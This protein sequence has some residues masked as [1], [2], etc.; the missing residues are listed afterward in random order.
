MN[1][2]LPRP[3]T[4]L[5]GVLTSTAFV[6]HDFAV[7]ALVWESVYRALLLSAVAGGLIGALL[8][9]WRW[10]PVAAPAVVIGVLRPWEYGAALILAI[11]VLAA[12]ILWYRIK[13]RRFE[14]STAGVVVVVGVLWVMQVVQAVSAAGLPTLTPRPVS[15]SSVAEGQSIYIVIADAYP[16]ADTL[17]DTFGI[18]NQ[19]FLDDLAALGFTVD[20]G[21]TSDYASTLHTMTALLHGEEPDIPTDG[22]QRLWQRLLADAPIPRELQ[23]EGW[24]VR[25]VTSAASQIT[26]PPMERLDGSGFNLVE[27][28]TLGQTLI[29]PLLSGWILDDLRGWV[30]ETLDTLPRLAADDQRQLVIAHVL[31]PHPPFLWDDSGAPDCWPR[32]HLFTSDRPTL[33]LTTDEY[34][35]LLRVQ[36]DRL[37]PL[38]LDSLQRT[39]AAD[40]D[41]IMVLMSDH[42]L[43][44]NEVG[45]AGTDEWSRT[46]L[47]IRGAEGMPDRLSDL[48]PFL[49]GG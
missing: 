45:T 44:H 23:A 13:H 12:V 38:I 26:F 24:T 10:G 37:N 21:A 31:A 8:S 47:A 14:P 17:R 36:L 41:A 7:N 43:R 32:C 49:L 25:V 48:L 46:L 42:G 33:G 34:G 35:A 9:R 1:R 30:V 3:L 4:V 39:I 16:R 27:I 20:S 22:D 6:L 18:D 40:P 19:P 11:L 28:E 29:G 5:I 15:A 2:A